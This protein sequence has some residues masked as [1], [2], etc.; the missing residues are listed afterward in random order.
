V[1]NGIQNI[2]S[3]DCNIEVTAVYNSAGSVLNNVRKLDA[4]VTMID[5]Q[6]P[7]GN[8][9]DIAKETLQIYPDMA[10]LVFSSTDEP[11][12]IRKMQ[13]LGCKGYLLKNADND[14]ILKAV[15]ALYNGLRYLSPELE[16]AI[17]NKMLDH[18]KENKKINPHCPVKRTTYND[19]TSLFQTKN[20]IRTRAYPFQH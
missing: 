19:R 2:L 13:L 16:G 12:Q 15:E 5:M 1:T 3:A 9:Y 7:D 11:Y 17:I 18:K 6:L 8:G 20:C 10:I 14:I 4:D